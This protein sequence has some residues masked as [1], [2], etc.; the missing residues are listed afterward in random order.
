MRNDL[1]TLLKRAN[2]N[3]KKELI[4]IIF[5]NL[6]LVALMIISYV[7]THNNLLLIP[8]I[9][10][11]VLTN[12]IS[13]YRYLFLYSKNLTSQIKEFVTLFRYL[14]LD[15]N[16]EIKPEAA[17]KNLKAYASL[18]MNEQLQQLLDSSQTDPSLFPYL[19]FA[20][21][22]S[23]VLVEEVMLNLYRFKKRETNENLK[24]FNNAYFKLK[25]LVEQEDENNSKRQYD[26][27]K[28]TAIIGTAIIVIVLI[29]SVILITEE[30]LNG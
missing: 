30:Y 23:S 19:N 2:L 14:Y 16:N 29:I 5:I 10:L 9:F 17:L 3:Y 28:S 8:F 1:K 7:L 4:T 11:I 21:L 18:K 26:F 27:I 20:K 12:A 22:F 15:I 25:H 13:F 24:H 6:F